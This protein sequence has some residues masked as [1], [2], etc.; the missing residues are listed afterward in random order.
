[1][2][3]AD[4][5]DAASNDTAATAVKAIA[6]PRWIM[7]PPPDVFAMPR[8]F[9]LTDH[10]IAPERWQRPVN[11]PRS[12]PIHGSGQIVAIARI[13]V[14]AARN[15]GR[16]AIERIA[17]GLDDG[18]DLAFGDDVVDLNQDRRELAGGG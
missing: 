18:D 7:V 15:I 4:T 6:L 13:N 12:P 11:C 3:C 9:F 17:S 16:R 1:M 8:T 14:S 5:A 2:S 10:V